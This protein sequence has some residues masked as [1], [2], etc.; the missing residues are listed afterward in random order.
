MRLDWNQIRSL[1]GRDTVQPGDVVTV[2]GQTFGVQN[3]GA[4]G[5]EFEE[6]EG[7]DDGEAGD[8]EEQE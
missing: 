6:L 3:V 8:D 2:N 4:E 5:A 1:F 7:D